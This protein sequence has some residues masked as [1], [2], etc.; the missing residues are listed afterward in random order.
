MADA[1]S[2]MKQ[3]DPAVEGVLCPEWGRKENVRCQG[4]AAEY[5][6]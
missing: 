6:P 5:L 3:R 1:S 2:V 4:W